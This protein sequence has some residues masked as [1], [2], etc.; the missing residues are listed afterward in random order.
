[1]WEGNFGTSA[2][3]DLLEGVRLIWGLLN[4]GFTVHVTTTKLTRQHDVKLQA[5]PPTKHGDSPTLF[6]TTKFAPE[7]NSGETT[8]MW[9]IHK[10][11]L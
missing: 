10:K 9:A 1:M 4:T 7:K 3:V 2:G 11:N 8:R 6:S 5:T